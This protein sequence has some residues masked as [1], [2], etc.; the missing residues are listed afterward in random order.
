M[1]PPIRNLEWLIQQ[2]QFKLG[3]NPSQPDM[4]FR[5]NAADPDKHYR[6]L[7]NEAGDKE[8]ED[9][10]LVGHRD[11]FIKYHEFVWPAATVTLAVPAPLLNL[12]IRYMHD[13]T[14][15]V[16]GTRLPW[17]DGRPGEGV[18]L[19]ENKTMQWGSS[20]PSADTTIRATYMTHFVEMTLPIDEPELI[21][22]RYR[23][24]LVWSALDIAQTIGDQRVP[25]DVQRHLDKWRET[26]YAHLAKGSPSED[27]ISRIIDRDPDGYGP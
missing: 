11:R 20:G 22:P 23:W 7:I 9:A 8:V 6:S 26:W 3:G 17:T 2:F 24:I 13:V 25:Q 18:F 14:N 19:K 10:S 5:G 12:E 21:A 16:V 4:S 27:N 15:D 1:A